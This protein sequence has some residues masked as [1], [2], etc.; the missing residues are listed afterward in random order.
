M[1]LYLRL[2]MLMMKSVKLEPMLT[3]TPAD[4]CNTITTRIYPNDLD[5]NLHVNNGCYLTLCDLSRFDLF[6]RTGLAKL[7]IKNK[8]NPIICSHEMNY[9][10]PLNLFDK[11][12]IKMQCEHWDEKYFYFKHEFFKK[13]KLVAHGTSKA[14]IISKQ[15]SLTPE[16]VLDAVAEYQQKLA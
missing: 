4:L 7:M 8:W 14:L 5:I 9:L 2:L 16:F 15:G 10:R 11:I 1:N 6:I 3:N 13:G 12:T